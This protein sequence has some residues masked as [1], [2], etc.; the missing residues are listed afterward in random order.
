MVIIFRY[1]LGVEE[2]WWAPRSSK[3]LRGTAQVALVGSTPIHSRLNNYQP[4]C[5]NDKYCCSSY[6][7]KSPYGNLDLISGES[8]LHANFGSWKTSMLTIPAKPVYIDPEVYNRPNCHATGLNAYCLSCVALISARCSQPTLNRLGAS[9]HAVM[10]KT[11]L[12]MMLFWCLP[13]G[14]RSIQPGITIG[15]TRPVRTAAL[16]K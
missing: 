9:A 8:K 14:C 15:A 16:A 4:V 6:S 3:S 10:A 12:A 5:C 11:A 1:L 7:L 13:L 2:S